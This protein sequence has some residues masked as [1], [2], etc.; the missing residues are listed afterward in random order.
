MKTKLT[1]LALSLQKI[2]RR[3]IQLAV[4]MTALTLMVL[5]VGA[6]DDGGYPVGH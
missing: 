1:Q 2:D 4:L 3:Y 6:P 5:G